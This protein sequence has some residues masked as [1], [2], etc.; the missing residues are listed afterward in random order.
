[1]AKRRRLETPS[2]ADLDRIEEQFRSETSERL[3]PLRGIA[4]IAQVA[5]DSAAAAPTDSA[6]PRAERAR[7]EAD[8]ARLSAAGG[9]GG[10]VTYIA[11]S[12]IVMRARSSAR[13]KSSG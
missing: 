13:R 11:Q 3:T 4:P 12:R 1:M 9:I 6:G 5:G 7:L 10:S 2:N 8:A